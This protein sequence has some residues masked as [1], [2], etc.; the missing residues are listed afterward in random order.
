MRICVFGAGA[1]GGN[2]AVRLSAAGHDVSVVARGEHLAAI[3]R[4][5]LALVAGDQQIIGNVRA[6][7]RTDEL[8][9]QDVVVSTLKATG[10]A[11]LAQQIT[12]LLGADTPIVFAQNGIP[13]W[14]PI[15]LASDRPVPPDLS[16][17]DPG[18]L[19]AA[20]VSRERV[21]GAVILSS[22]QVIEPG[23]IRN[24]SPN[25]NA[26]VIGEPD[27]V[28]STRVAGLR[29][30]LEQAGIQSPRT[31]DIR[32][33]LWNKLLMN[34]SASTLCLLTEQPVSVL[35]NDAALREISARLMQEGAA[36]AAAHGMQFDA[37]RSDADFMSRIGK[38]ASHRPSILQDYE[39]GRPMEIDSII[40][41]PQLFGQAAGVATPTLDVVAAL[42]ARRAAARGSYYFFN[43]GQT[44][45]ASGKNA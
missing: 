38:I 8:G 21:I 24:D 16:R 44:L 10:L 26:L 19:L 23:V 9:R 32:K 42:A 31:D 35:A 39:L 41:M 30:A 6:A 3:R 22:N 15:G 36:I 7:D 4:N 45:L 13:W 14:Y 25:S 17:L 37:T 28:E 27:D 11:A 18:G 20:A 29:V 12:P 2:L 34:L 33:S 43:I 40:L 1:V 5:G